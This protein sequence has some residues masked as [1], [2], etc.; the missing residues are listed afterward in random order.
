MVN[1]I[2]WELRT[3]RIVADT[4]YVSDTPEVMVSQYLWGDLQVHRVMDY[5][6]W[7]QFFQ[8]LELVPNIDLYLFL[9]RYP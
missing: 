1:V 8:Q 9:N 6:L 5:F 3:V 2:L 7:T 4:A